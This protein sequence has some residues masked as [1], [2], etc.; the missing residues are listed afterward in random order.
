MGFWEIHPDSDAYRVLKDLT[1][2]EEWW[3][4]FRFKWGATIGDAWPEVH[5]KVLGGKKRHGDFP[6]FL[7]I[8]IFSERALKLLLPLIRDS[9][10]VLPLMCETENL[11]AINVVRVMDC[12]DHDLSEFEKFSDGRIM[13]VENYVFKEH[14]L[15]GV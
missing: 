7:G 8:P 2:D 14:C 10:E 9:I 1:A 3:L 11:F 12:L 13:R 15:D 6:S 5:V 4:D